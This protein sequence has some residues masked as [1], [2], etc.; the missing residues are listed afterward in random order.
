MKVIVNTSKKKS[1][2]E[3][4]GWT[5]LKETQKISV[6]PSFAT[7]IA[8]TSKDLTIRRRVV[9]NIQYLVP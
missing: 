8:L 3:R 1:K 5:P 4:L 9:K 6:N 2:G 7:G